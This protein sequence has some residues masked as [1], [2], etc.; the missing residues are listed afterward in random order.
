VADTTTA[1]G[2]AGSTASTA[3]AD[4]AGSVRDASASTR[5]LLACGLVGPVLFW[6]LGAAAM[7]SWPGYD[8]VADSISGLIYAPEGW[9][10]E[11]AFIVLAVLTMAFAVGMGR[12]AGATSADRRQVRGSLLVL[13][14]LELGFAVFP[15]NAPGGASFHGTAH[16]VTLGV[17]AIAFPFLGFRVAAVLRRDRPWW[18]AGVLTDAVSVT[19]AIAIVGVAL[20]VFGPLDPWTGL[21]ER[22]WV[23]VPSLWLAGLALHG[24]LV[25]AGR[26]RGSAPATRAGA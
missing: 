2:A 19:M 8:A 23:A 5:L 10:Q 1:A 24:L 14:T 3:P 18:R 7:R 16:M 17:F 22:M 9:L 25:S 12:I 15:A 6:V 13:A 26:I 21:L 20:V 4:G 11:D